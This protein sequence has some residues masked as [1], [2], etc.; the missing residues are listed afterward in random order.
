MSTHYA[1]VDLE[2]A[3]S[4]IT[5][6]SNEMSHCFAAFEGISHIIELVSSPFQVQQQWK[7]QADSFPDVQIG[8]VAFELCD[9][10]ADVIART[11][12]VELNLVGF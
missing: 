11:Q 4:F 3:S 12:F 10:R 2:A 8:P 9:L 5:D 7:T 6:I 1:N